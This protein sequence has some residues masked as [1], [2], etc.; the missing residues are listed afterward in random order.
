MSVGVC[1]AWP[2]ISRAGT[3]LAPIDSQARDGRSMPLVLS[4]VEVSDDVSHSGCRLLNIS[5]T[6]EEV[7]YELP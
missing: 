7:G 4:L 6:P 1:R 2:S 3:I 5:T